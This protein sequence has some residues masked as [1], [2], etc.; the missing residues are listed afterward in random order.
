MTDDCISCGSCEPECP[1][2]A[3]SMG[4]EH[5]VIDPDTCIDCGACAGLCPVE[6]I[7]PE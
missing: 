5:Y 7:K 4:S 2:S 3:I 6:A 1:V